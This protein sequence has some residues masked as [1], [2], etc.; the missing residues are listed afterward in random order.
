MDIDSLLRVVLDAGTRVHDSLGPGFLESIYSR[1]LLIELR[2]RGLVIEK[3]KQVKIWYGSQIVGK[4]CLDLII[5][6]TIVVEMKA[7]QSLAPTHAAQLRS[8]LHAA[9]C[10]MGILFNFGAPSLQWEVHRREVAEKP[11]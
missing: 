8:Y 11:D 1:A 9:D 7:G 2:I 4:H 5:E 6:K 3:E 10:S